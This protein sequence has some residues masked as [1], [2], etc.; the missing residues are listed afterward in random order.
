MY[1]MDPKEAQ[2]D[3]GYSI[4]LMTIGR[5]SFSNVPVIRRYFCLNR[6]API[7]LLITTTPPLMFPS[8]H[9]QCN[10][11]YNSEISVLKNAD[12]HRM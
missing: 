11:V 4:S 3:Y 2:T 9:K 10:I 12:K 1:P 7:T 5:G 6:L 8:W